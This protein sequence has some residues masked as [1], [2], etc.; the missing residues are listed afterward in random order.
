GTKDLLLLTGENGVAD[1]GDIEVGVVQDR[2]QV[3]QAERGRDLVARIF[4]NKPPSLHQDWINTGAE[5]ARHRLGKGE[6]RLPRNS[7]RGKR[8]IAP[9]CA[10]E[11]SNFRYGWSMCRSVETRE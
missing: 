6:V 4:Q 2:P 8:Q 7:P 3:L 9:S 5:Y 10:G 11:A 1:N